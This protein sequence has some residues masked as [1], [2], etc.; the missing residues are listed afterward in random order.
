MS[1]ITIRCRLVAGVK[2]KIIGKSI[3]NFSAEEQVLLQNLLN[4]KI[5]VELDENKDKDA[6]VKAKIKKNTFIT[7]AESSEDVRKQLW[8]FF[9]TSSSLTDE[10]LDRLS[11][12]PNFKTWLQQGNLPDDE[13][14]AC[15]LE[16]KTSPLY[17]EKLPGRFFSSVQS[18]VKTIGSTEPAMQV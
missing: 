15:W 14:K 5:Q 1:I 16:L 2:K 11:Q 7:L 10:L 9:L 8:H 18:M 17:D 3:K 6:K 4:E 12:H 13:L